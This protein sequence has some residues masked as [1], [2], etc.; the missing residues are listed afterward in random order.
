M[1]TS[2]KTVIGMSIAYLVSLL[3]MG[4]AWWRLRKDRRDGGR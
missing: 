1:E 2:L 3:G 4:L